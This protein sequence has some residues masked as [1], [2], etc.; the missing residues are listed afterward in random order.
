L[1]EVLFSS[2]H[3]KYSESQGTKDPDK[4]SQLAY[5][6]AESDL[7]GLPENQIVSYGSEAMKADK[8]WRLGRGIDPKNF[9]RSAGFS[10][11][12]ACGGRGRGKLLV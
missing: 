6:E 8:L 2:I 10:H 1:L 4:A 5:G 3:S 7:M 12:V 11:F 9:D